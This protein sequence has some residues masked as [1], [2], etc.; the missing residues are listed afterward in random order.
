[1]G[2]QP[3]FM[4]AVDPDA[5]AALQAEIAALRREVRA[6]RMVPKPEWV[7]AAEYAKQLGVTRRT[8]MNRIAA[9]SIQSSRQGNTVLVRANPDA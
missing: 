2:E 3:K 4:V 5:L 9:G 7:T 1:M 8:V 6:V